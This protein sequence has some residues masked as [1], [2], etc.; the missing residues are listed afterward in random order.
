MSGARG[1]GSCHGSRR[2]DRAPGKNQ[3]KIH[4]LPCSLSG[5]VP[6]ALCTTAVLVLPCSIAAL[7]CNIPCSRAKLP[8]AGTLD[9]LLHHF[10]SSSAYIV[11]CAP[12]SKMRRLRFMLPVA[13]AVALF[14]SPLCGGAAAAATCITGNGTAQQPQQWSVSLLFDQTR[15][16]A[17]A[18]AQQ[19]VALALQADDVVAALNG[20]TLSV[21]TAL[22]DGCVGA[23]PTMAIA[24]PPTQV[25]VAALLNATAASVVC[26]F[27]STV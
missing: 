1:R 14:A 17:L 12:P 4:W 5:C 10:Q 27:G 7:P 20:D 25:A 22:D 18:R 3:K 23:R 8:G 15:P 6:L 16:K 19:A 21:N 2:R 24:S 26:P 11:N 9:Q 13:V